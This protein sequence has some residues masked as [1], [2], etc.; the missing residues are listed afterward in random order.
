MCPNK[1]YF[2]GMYKP[3]LSCSLCFQRCGQANQAVRVWIKVFKIYNEEN[4]KTLKVDKHY[5]KEKI[6]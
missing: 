2:E 3:D 6:E 5:L 4:E 1:T